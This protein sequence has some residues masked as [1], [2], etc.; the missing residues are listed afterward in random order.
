MSGTVGNQKV[1]ALK[2][3][4]YA[5][6]LPVLSRSLCKKLGGPSSHSPAR[7]NL[8]R[9]GSGSLKPPKPGATVKR[10]QPQQ[11]RRTLERVLTNDRTSQKPPPRLS[12]SATDSLVPS[13]K[14]E[15][16]ELSLSRVSVNKPG[17]HLSKRYSQREVDLTAVSQAKESKAKKKAEVEQELQGA[18]AALKRPNP[19]MAVKEL[20]E[21]A[22]RRATGAKSRSMFGS[23]SQA[24]SMLMVHRTETPS[25]QPVRAKCPNHG[26]TKRHSAMGCLRKP[27]FSDPET[28]HDLERG[29]GDTS[30]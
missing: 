8:K 23:L 4:S 7:P 29:R 25:P 1:G 9:I 10:S 21:S 27:N 28:D 14:R 3:S 2:L 13:L 30:A 11:A 15:P 5:A 18:I 24:E 17:L 19:R 12:R 6:R 26:N 22:E 20:V 16:S